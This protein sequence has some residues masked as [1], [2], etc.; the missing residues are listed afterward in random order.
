[1]MAAFFDASIG[2]DRNPSGLS[3]PMM[4]LPKTLQPSAYEVC[5]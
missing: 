4:K 3:L 5:F 2:R 1:M